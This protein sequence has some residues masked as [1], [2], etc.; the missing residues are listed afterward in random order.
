MLVLSR[1]AEERIVFPELGIS[2]IV[3]QVRGKTVTLGI[4]APQEIRVL[5]GELCPEQTSNSQCEPKASTLAI[6][7]ASAIP[8]FA[9]A[10]VQ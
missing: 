10:S 6:S 1:R 7:A 3:K 8:D 5:R 4:D 2:V 9:A